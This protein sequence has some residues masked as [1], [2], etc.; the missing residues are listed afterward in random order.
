MKKYYYVKEVTCPECGGLGIYLPDHE[1]Y[2]HDMGT[3]YEPICD[4][5]RG[6]GYVLET[7]DKVTGYSV[8][9]TTL[10]VIEA[11][12]NVNHTSY[13]TVND[14][15][16]EYYGI[17]DYEHYHVVGGKP[18]YQF[19]TKNWIYSY[20]IIPCYR[21]ESRQGKKLIPYA[22]TFEDEVCYVVSLKVEERGE[23]I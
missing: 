19:V 12:G 8:V 5:C 21:P 14:V 17:L 16:A 13:E 18:Y 7:V 1:E 3:D 2:L 15:I 10:E 20:R 22:I 11:K 6:N 9:D 4:N 23:I